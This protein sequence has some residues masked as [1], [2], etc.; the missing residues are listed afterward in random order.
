MFK[1]FGESPKK[2][3]KPC[4]RVNIS[5]QQYSTDSI[6]IDLELQ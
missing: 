2:T 3:N 1:T 6:Y 4:C 5:V